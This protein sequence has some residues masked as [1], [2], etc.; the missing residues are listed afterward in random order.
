MS[1]VAASTIVYLVLSVPFAQGTEDERHHGPDP[2]VNIPDTSLRRLVEARYADDTD[3]MAGHFRAGARAISNIV[4]AQSEDQPNPAGASDMLWQWGQ[5]LDHDISLTGHAAPPEYALIPVPRWDA[6]FDPHGH[7]AATIEFSR[8][9]HAHDREGVRQQVNEV[10]GW[11]D[12]SHIYG[13]DA[14][15]ANALRA[16]DGSGRLQVSSGDLLPFNLYGL[17]N[18]GGPSP[19]LFLAGDIRANEQVGLTTLHTLFVREHNRLA[20]LL[21]ARYPAAGGDTIYNRARRLVR[22]EIQH[23]TYNEFLPAL[24]GREA[25]PDYRG[26]RHDADGRI[27][28]AFSSA[29]YRFGHSMLSSRLLRLDADLEPIA[30][31]HLP[32]A[33]AFFA[34]HEVQA[35]GIESVLRGLTQQR[36]Q[37]ADVHLV[38]DVRN[39]LFGNPGRGGFDLAAL[40]IQRGRDHGLPSY[41]K[42][43]DKLD[44]EEVER[45][46]DVS[47]DAALVDRLQTAYVRVRDIDLWVGG[48]AED[49]VAGSHLGELF[50]K[51]ISEQFEA[52]RDADPIWYERTLSHRERQLIEGLTLARIIRLNTAIG[53]EL[54]DDVFH[55]AGDSESPTDRQQDSEQEQEQ[56]EENINGLSVRDF[57]ET[58]LR[59]SSRGHGGGH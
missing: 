40:N 53:H 59:H 6:Q 22:A 58:I 35:H 2:R 34:T 4:S 1:L 45:F 33:R 3:G 9:L 23:I 17:P 18:A 48:L 19:H 5:F 13:S 56:E 32:L 54:P 14:T 29:A 43:R 52:L 50:H 44:L 12:A 26:F 28:N 38:D 41:T 30:A 7:G 11:I 10:T 31:G 47:S 16:H 24:L 57:L 51:I 8:S 39:F 25:L 20:E 49:P 21:R 55:V 15:R 27:S 46:S 37:T 42:M 36:A